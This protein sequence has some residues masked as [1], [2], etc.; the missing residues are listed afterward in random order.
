M[1]TTKSLET[2]IAEVWNS[3]LFMR[4][5]TF[6]RTQ[7]N[8]NSG[9][10]VEL[11]D[12][13]GIFG[14]TL[15]IYQVKQRE[16]DSDNTN[17]KINDWLK[18]KVINKATKQISNTHFFLDSHDEIIIS[19][20]RGKQF[21]LADKKYTERVNLV[22]HNIDVITNK[23]T[24]YTKIR[25]NSK[26]LT[27]HYFSVFEFQYL[28]R[29]CLVPIEFM[30]YISFRDKYFKKFGN[31]I[32]LIDE[33]SLF[34]AYLG[35]LEGSDIKLATRVY[36]GIQIENTEKIEN[37]KHMFYIFGDRLTTENKDV[38]YQLLEVML[39]LDRIFYKT[40]AERIHISIEN[41]D[42]K[43][44]TKP[45]RFG[46][47]QSGIAVIVI[48]FDYNENYKNLLKKWSDKTEGKKEILWFLTKLHKYDLKV[49]RAIGVLISKA[50]TDNDVLWNYLDFP[51][52]YS[53][54]NNSYED[55]IKLLF[56]PVKFKISNSYEIR[57]Q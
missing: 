53:E 49:D 33:R 14:N 15:I 31:A 22:I 37:M 56:E 19:N 18:K 11:A 6:S 46:S 47:L 13:I 17:A 23:Y 27:I 51:W 36:R 52:E 8:P 43:F 3:F 39:P 7:F 26:G 41:L 9:S 48:P 25:V 34:Y 50:G 29:V 16:E 28:C 5:F 4:E 38:Y 45:H 20:H 40:L 35:H 1:T 57:N 42:N 30:N 32:N 10:E 55:L 12:G 54:K 44:P 2:H 21:N 24:E